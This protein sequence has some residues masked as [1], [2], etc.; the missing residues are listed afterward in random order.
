MIPNHLFNYLLLSNQYQ[1]RLYYSERSSNS[2][3]ADP[4]E[5]NFSTCGAT[6][7]IKDYTTRLYRPKEAR[8]G[9]YCQQ[10]F[11]AA[12]IVTAVQCRS[13]R[14]AFTALQVVPRC[15][16]SKCLIRSRTENFGF[17]VL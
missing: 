11:C 15:K 6:T 9:G 5:L 10:S 14:S 13:D 16:R 12:E 1:Y 3:G 8:C 4:H 7:C 17:H 2:T